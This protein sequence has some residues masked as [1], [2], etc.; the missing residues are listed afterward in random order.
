M[1]VCVGER[2]RERELDGAS[3]HVNVLASV[4]T[5]VRRCIPQHLNENERKFSFDTQNKKRDLNPM[6]P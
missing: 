4:L 3:E 2:E 5:R 1:R 6:P